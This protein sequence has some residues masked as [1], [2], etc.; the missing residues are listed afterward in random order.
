MPRRLITD[1]NRTLCLNNVLGIKGAGE[2]GSIGAPPAIMNAVLD[3]LGALGVS[4]IDMPVT[5]MRVWRAIREAETAGAA[6]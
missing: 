4:H 3:A 6:R 2:G 1:S 5:P